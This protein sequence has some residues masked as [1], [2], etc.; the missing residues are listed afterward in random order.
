MNAQSRTYLAA[1]L[2]ASTLPVFAQNAKRAN[3]TGGVSPHETTSAVIDGS[4][5]TLTYGRPFSKDPKT[6]EPRKI[7]GSLVPWDKAWRTGADEA[8]TLIT[9]QPLAFGDTTLAA[10][11]YTVY[12]VP[13]ESG[14]SKLVFSSHLGKWGV[15]VDEKHDVARVDLKKSSPEKPVDQFTMAVAK[16]ESGGGVIKLVWEDVQFSVPF[17]V[18]K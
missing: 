14:T 8:T 16:G 9:E 18:K 10:G 3:S 4:R 11:A 13:S 5:V 15:P 12:T 17:S 6:G 2:L 1:A 7:W